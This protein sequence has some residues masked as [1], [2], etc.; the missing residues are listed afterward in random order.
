MLVVALV[1]VPVV[2]LYT[3]WVFRVLRGPVTA[4]GISRDSHGY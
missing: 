4:A 3:A 2:A 1:F